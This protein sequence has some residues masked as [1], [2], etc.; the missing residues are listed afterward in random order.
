M[1]GCWNKLR[2]W[3][4]ALS[5]GL[6]QNAVL[7]ADLHLLQLLPLSG[8]DGG[9]GWHIQVGA[10]VAVAQAN[11]EQRL[12]GYSLK[13]ISQDE[14]RGHIAEQLRKAQSQ[15]NPVALLGLYGRQTLA[16]LAQSKLLDGLGLPVIGLQS[17]MVSGPGLD[18]PWLFMTRGSHADEVEAVFLHLATVASRRLVLVT[19]DDEDGQEI[20]ALVRQAAQQRGVSVRIAPSHSAD[21]AQ[22]SAAVEATLAQP[23]D[24]VL[25]A[26]NTSAV[27]N[28]AKLYVRGGGKGQLIALASAEATQLSAIVGAEAARGV[29]ISQMV[30]NPRDP[31]L[32]L[33]REFQAAFKRFGPE[34]RQPSLVMTESYIATRVL[35]EALRRSG[36]SGSRPDGAA[37]LRSLAALPSPLLVGDLPVVLN[38]RGQ[39]LR[40]LSMIGRDGALVF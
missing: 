36:G 8:F 15:F 11:A 13:L 35:I 2:P 7:A 14:Q 1:G 27:A 4:L 29:L 30:P 10:E 32:A 39:A 12:P 23:H 19:T 21:S 37:V 33:M 22:V 31:K 26:S 24:V 5:L 9:T 3:L 20:T 18:A 16:E 17:G 28:F 38:R 25:L 34:G 40:G 6:L